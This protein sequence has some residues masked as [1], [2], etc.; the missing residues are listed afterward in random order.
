VVP[1]RNIRGSVV[2]DNKDDRPAFDIPP[3]EIIREELKHR[4]WSQDDLARIIG[5]PQSRINELIQGKLAISPDLAV[6]LAAAIGETPELW[7]QR[8]AAYRLRIA[9][10]DGSDVRR[11]ARLY[12]IAPV[13]EMQKRGWIQKAINDDELETELKTYFDL[14]RIE[15]DPAIHGAMRKTGANLAATCQQVAWAFRVRQL[16]NAIPQASVAKYVESKMD[17]CKRDLRKLAAFSAEVRKVPKLLMNYGIRFVVV[18]GLA[19][20]K[21][22]GFATWLNDDTPLIGMSLRYDRLDSFWFTLGHELA[23]IKNRDLAPIDGDV[24]GHDDPLEVKTVVERRADAESAAM[25][26]SPDEFESFIRRVG[27]LYSTERINQFANTIKIHPSIIIGQLKNRG[28]IGYSKHTKSVPVRDAVIKAAVTD[29][30]G[31]SLH[32]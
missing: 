3:G 31:K 12:E 20:A 24:S 30:W 2:E 27:P 18:E 16:G 10:I 4:G 14:K 28:Q 26:I 17:D 9:G 13:R 23:H 8:E 21:M 15:D 5:R 22:D 7:L 19:G 29:G 6:A 25:F 1:N 32:T 11:R